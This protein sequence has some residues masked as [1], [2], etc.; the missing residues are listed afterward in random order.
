MT[1]RD[2]L[3]N[4]LAEATAAHANAVL[5]GEVACACDSRRIPPAASDT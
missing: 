5:S 1:A 4:Q 2:A 3:R